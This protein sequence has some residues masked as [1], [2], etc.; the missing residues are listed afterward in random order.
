MGLLL[1]W[2]RRGLK[3]GEGTPAREEPLEKRL[4]KEILPDTIVEIGDVAVKLLKKKKSK[5]A[6]D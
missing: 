3:L 5:K 6:K 1:D 2:A 4:A